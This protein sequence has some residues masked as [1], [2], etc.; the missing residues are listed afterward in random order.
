MILQEIE[1]YQQRNID[2]SVLPEDAVNWNAVC[3]RRP[4]KYSERWDELPQSIFL[5]KSWEM[6]D[7][8]WAMN[9][10]FVFCL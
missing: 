3:K 10:C 6:E 2:I 9:L 5:I 8:I 1:L 4:M 7:G